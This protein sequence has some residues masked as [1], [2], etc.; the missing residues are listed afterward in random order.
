M[1][2]RVQ[3]RLSPA[4]PR[5]LALLVVAVLINY[6]DR[7]N[8]SIAAPLLKDEFRL[9][10]SQLGI[11]L[12]SFFWTYTLFQI[13]SGWAV[14]RFDVN[15]VIAAGFLTWSLATAATAL[16]HGF[17]LLLMIRLIL[18]IGESAA[19]PSC[20]KILARH[21]AERRRGL[22][23]ALIMTGM[24]LGPALGT[25][26][27][28]MLMARFGWRPFFL[29][30]GL[31]SLV[32]LLP[33]LKWM[34]REQTPTQPVLRHSPGLLEIL[35]QR[36]AW[37]A[38][39]G[40]FCGNYVWYFLLTWLPFYLVRE[41]DFSMGRV[42]KIGGMVYL[43]AAV[44]AT[45]SGWLSD[46]WI[47]KGGT[48]TR[49]RKTFMFVGYTCAGMSLMLCVVSGRDLF[50]TLLMVASASS[51]IY[52][53]N[54]WAIA[55]TLAGPQAAGK[56]TGLQNFMGNLAG[57]VVPALTGLIVQR[58]GQFF[59]AFATTAI[60]ALLGAMFW[61]FWVGRVE[62]VVWSHPTASNLARAAVDA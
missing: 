12:S 41:R 57:V 58:T 38:C 54:T 8:L 51:G 24:M 19:F 4:L 26:A 18:G 60:V 56:W 46:S 50:V 48:P 35:R 52:A 37:G 9:S 10:A 44:F 5:V 49:V 62:E 59:W 29:V 27:G 30:L 2:M 47:A 3:Q 45:I 13:V 36:S 11:L 31:V 53:S 34:P 16:V 14:D 7:S 40:Q 21:C 42:A 43:V 15:W 39:A 20:S 33:W 25:F 23:N 22:A 61:F 17:I 28:G 32:W 55:Q 1:H 6:I